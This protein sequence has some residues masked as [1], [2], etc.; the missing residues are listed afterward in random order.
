MGRDESTRPLRF[1]TCGMMAVIAAS[2]A[3]LPCA[4]YLLPCLCCATTLG[5]VTAVPF[6]RGGNRRRQDRKVV[7]VPQPEAAVKDLH[8]ACLVLE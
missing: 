3:E 7:K 5:G 8:P 4:L 2:L 6:H 1:R